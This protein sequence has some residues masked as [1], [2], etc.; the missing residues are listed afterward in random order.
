MT[1]PLFPEMERQLGDDP[2]ARRGDP[3]TAVSAAAAKRRN[4]ATQSA[5][6][7]LLAAFGATDHVGAT[8]REAA[9]LAG[10]PLESEYA[11]RC[12]ELRARRLIEFTPGQRK[13]PGGMARKLSRITA[14]GRAL[15]AEVGMA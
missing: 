5:R 9:V 12:S 15:L 7:K 2:K 11:T 14:K 13:S 6:L 8:D 1:L 3:D 10:V 4:P